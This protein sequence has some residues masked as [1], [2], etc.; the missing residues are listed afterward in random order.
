MFLGHFPVKLEPKV[1]QNCA[2]RPKE[3]WRLAM[4]LS[5]ARE[6]E[7]N[8]SPGPGLTKP[9]KPTEPTDPAAVNL[10]EPYKEGLISDASS[11][12]SFF[13]WSTAV[14]IVTAAVGWMESSVMNSVGNSRKWR[15][16]CLPSSNGSFYCS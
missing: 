6:R 15:E 10:T 14:N 8:P 12:S 3:L 2:Y 11:S 7:S 16:I 1:A 9:T 4:S 5:K 13:S